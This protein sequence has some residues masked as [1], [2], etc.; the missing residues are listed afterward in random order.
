LFQ[1]FFRRPLF[2]SD[3][4]AAE[5]LEIGSRVSGVIGR[6]W[7]RVGAAS[8]SAFH[9]H[10]DLFQRASLGSGTTRKVKYQAATLSTA[11]VRRAVELP[12]AASSL[13]AAGV[14][15]KF[16]SHSRDSELSVIPLS[17]ITLCRAHLI[18]CTDHAR[19]VERLPAFGPG[20]NRHSILR[21]YA[22]AVAA[23]GEC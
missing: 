7:Q 12:S 15:A 4:A 13:G 10:S 19:Q 14:M 22:R 2:I 20:I 17:V 6:A 9:L 8:D 23:V 1:Q 3:A 16:D 5:L 11:K 18:A 21:S